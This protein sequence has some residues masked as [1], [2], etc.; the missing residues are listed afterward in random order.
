MEKL[1]QETSLWINNIN[2]NNNL[3]HTSNIFFNNLPTSKAHSDILGPF[4]VHPVSDYAKT[5]RNMNT[6]G[7]APIS[8]YDG[9]QTIV[10]MC[11]IKSQYNPLDPNGKGSYAYF[12]LFAG[13]LASVPC[14]NI[15]WA[16]VSIVT[17]KSQ[18][19]DILI[20][21]FVRKFNGISAKDQYE[22]KISVKKLV[23]ASLSYAGAQQK[24]AN[25]IQNLLDVDA[26]GNVYFNIYSSFFTI[27]QTSNKS[28]ITFQSE[29]F[30]T[31]I[32]YCLTASNWE[33]V[34]TLYADQQK[35][36]IDEWINN[37]TTQGKAGSKAKAPCLN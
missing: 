5:A 37:M 12:L 24:N 28:G 18:N 14:L 17:Q 8:I 2:S 16:E 11:R 1:I 3:V 22:L 15:Q 29:Y 25:F 6:F 34:R 23:T 30:L 9:L 26:R 32:S 31:Q 7:S 20:D 36:T 10:N 33:K 4:N 21:S 27:S 19:A 13:L 35:Q